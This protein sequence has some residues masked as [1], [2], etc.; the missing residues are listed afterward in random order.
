MGAMSIVGMRRWRKKWIGTERIIAYPVR[1]SSVESFRGR[2][3]G[4]RMRLEMTANA[5][6]VIGPRTRKRSPKEVW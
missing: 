6:A 5:C 2:P 1:L 4:D 3:V